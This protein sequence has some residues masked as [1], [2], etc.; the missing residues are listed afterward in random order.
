MC[1]AMRDRSVMTTRYITAT[2]AQ[3]WKDMNVFATTFLA[4]FTSSGKPMTDRIDVS[5][6]VMI[7]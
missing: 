6:R 5:L 2:I 1:L 4:V 7:N 3:V